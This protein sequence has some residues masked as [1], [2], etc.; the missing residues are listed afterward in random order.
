MPDGIFAIGTGLSALARR[1]SSSWDCEGLA[2]A[3]LLP[4]SNPQWNFMPHRNKVWVS[5]G[6]ETDCL[7]AYATGDQ[8][9]IGPQMLTRGGDSRSLASGGPKL[10]CREV[11]DS[12]NSLCWRG[13]YE[14]VDSVVTR[15]RD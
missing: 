5:N 13:P 2:K 9:N 6:G 10:P 12:K 14:T 3:Q 4:L 1:G 8:V 7:S 15:P 11:T